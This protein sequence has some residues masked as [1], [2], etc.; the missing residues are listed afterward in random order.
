VTRLSERKTKLQ[1]TTDAEVRYRGKMRAIVIEVNG[2][3]WF[4]VRLQGTRQR[5]ELS[6]MQVFEASA[7]LFARRE[8]DRR[9]KERM[10]RRKGMVGA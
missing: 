1:F 5:Y 3:Y 9:K 10:E 6:W 2:G 4:S 8:R 7:D